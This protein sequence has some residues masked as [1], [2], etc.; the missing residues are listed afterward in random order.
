MPT[1][2][3]RISRPALTPSSI[4]SLAPRSG[5]ARVARGHRSE[6]TLSS[7]DA[8]RSFHAL[9][10]HDEHRRS[11]R[12]RPVRGVQPQRGDR[13]GRGPVPD[14]RPGPGQT[15][16]LIQEDVRAM[17][18]LEVEGEDQAGFIDLG[19]LRRHPGRLHRV[20]LRRGAGG[21]AR[22]RDVLVEGLR[23]RDGPGHGPHDPR[24]GR[25]RA[26]HATAASCSRRSA[27]RRWSGGR[28]RRSPRSSTSTSTRSS[29]A[30][31]AELVRE[32]TFPFPVRVIA[33][34]LGLPNS[35]MAHFHRL[36]VELISVG[37]DMDRGLAA[38]QALGDYFGAIL[39]DRRTSPGRRSHEHARAGRARRAAPHRRRD[40][41]VPPPPAPGRRRDDVPLV[42]QPAVRPAQRSRAA[43]RAAQR[44]AR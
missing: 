13:R 28:S 8:A 24:D 33:R 19:A 26:P 10:A 2:T 14:V 25:A 20:H 35:E 30:A 11:D 43:R 40:L 15:A 12:V 1:I 5:P 39:A 23:G 6:L 21:A 36:A 17:A 18:G 22:R 16:P 41:R 37:F 27:A 31:R 32:L 7:A 4:S 34:L 44:T 29:T 3:R 9:E 42:G 38:S